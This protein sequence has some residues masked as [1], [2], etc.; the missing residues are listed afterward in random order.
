M[1]NI[2][3]ACLAFALSQVANARIDHDVVKTIKDAKITK[4]SC[5]ADQKS[6]RGEVTLEVIERLS[7]D[8]TKEVLKIDGLSCAKVY[9]NAAESIGCYSSAILDFSYVTDATGVTR[10]L[11]IGAARRQ[12]PCL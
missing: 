10:V 5:V 7:G 3:L 8:R 6:T 4:V 2:F 11:E 9:V 12:G 1:K